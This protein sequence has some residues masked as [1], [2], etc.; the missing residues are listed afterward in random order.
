M[1]P[2]TASTQGTVYLFHFHRPIGNLA[3]VR[4]QALH[5][6]GFAEDFE[7]RIAA[8]LAGKGAKL[9]AAALAQGIGYDLFHWPAALAVE[10]LIKRTKKTALYCPACCAT[11]GRPVRPLPTPAT[12]LALPLDLDDFDFPAP[13]ATRPDWL[14]IQIQRGWRQARAQLLEP[15]D[16]SRL[17]EC[18]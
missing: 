15:A 7:R 5:Y 1:W 18:L 6:V 12:Q 11:A 9:V 13:T 10:K 3:N 8:Q 17:D 14:E 16:L 2:W 4:A